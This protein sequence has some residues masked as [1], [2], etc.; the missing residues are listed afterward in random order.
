MVPLTSTGMEDKLESKTCEA[1]MGKSLKG[2]GVMRTLG[3]WGFVPLDLFR[4]FLKF[5]LFLP[6]SLSLT[7]C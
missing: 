7:L 6:D 2:G 3:I 5:F 4:V 1:G